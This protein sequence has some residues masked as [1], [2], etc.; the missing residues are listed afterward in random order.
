MFI[1]TTFPNNRK[2]YFGKTIHE[3]HPSLQILAKCMAVGF[4]KDHD[5]GFDW[6]IYA[7]TYK[8]PKGK[9]VSCIQG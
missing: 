9:Q 3:D 6:F 4:R 7:R 2:T 8:I 1:Q 5:D